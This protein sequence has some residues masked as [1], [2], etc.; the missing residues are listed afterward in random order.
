MIDR[1][2][3][4]RFDDVLEHARCQFKHIPDLGPRRLLFQCLYSD[5]Y[6]LEVAM[7]LKFVDNKLE[8]V[9]PNGLIRVTVGHSI[10]ILD[11]RRVSPCLKGADHI[12]NEMPTLYHTTQYHKVPSILAKGI[13][14]S[15]DGRYSEGR[16]TVHLTPWPC[17]SSHHSNAKAFGCSL[18]HE[19]ANC[20]SIASRWG[21]T[22]PASVQSIQWAQS[23]PRPSTASSSTTAGASTQATATTRMRCG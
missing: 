22:G 10:P 5:K 9:I 21:S 20:A 17:W 18:G 3:W 15:G 1:G 12:F 2:G 13:I 7:A 19:H 11:L 14:P 16:R 8:S 23:P 6:R 4:A